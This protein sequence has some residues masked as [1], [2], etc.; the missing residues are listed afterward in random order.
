MFCS[1]LRARYANALLR[2]PLPVAPRRVPRERGRDPDPGPEVGEISAQI[3][4]HRDVS[5]WHGDSGMQRCPG[6]RRCAVEN[7][8]DGA[9]MRLSYLWT[10]RCRPCRSRGHVDLLEEC[11]KVP[12]EFAVAGVVEAC[13]SQNQREK[14]LWSQPL[15]RNISLLIDGVALITGAGTWSWHHEQERRR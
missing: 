9:R 3:R 8:E 2:L 14:A 15:K 10:G 11:W 5:C 1:Q 4:A 6:R 7:R 12:A 13:W